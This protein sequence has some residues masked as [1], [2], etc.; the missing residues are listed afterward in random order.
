V[1]GEALAALQRLGFDVRLAVED[2]ARNAAMF[3][4]AGVPCVHVTAGGG[5]P[6]R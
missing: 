2:D 5:D 4:R 3:R 1:K 6:S